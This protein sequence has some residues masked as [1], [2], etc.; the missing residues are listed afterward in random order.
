MMVPGPVA[1]HPEVLKA[2]AAQPLH[3]HDL[4]FVKMF[5]RVLQGLREVFRAP[6]GQPIL[7]NGG[8]LLAM[9]VACA[10]FIEPKD[11]ILIINNGFFGEELIRVTKC[12]SRNVE[13]LTVPLGDRVPLKEV[14][15][16][17]YSEEFQV[18]AVSH[19]DTGSGVK[20]QLRQLVQSAQRTDTLTIVDTVSSVGGEY[21]EQSRWGIDV[22]FASTQKAIAGPPGIALL[23]LSEKAMRRLD[24]RKE[25]ISSIYMNLKQWITSMQ[26]YELEE[27][28]RLVSTP[29]SNLVAALDVALHLIQ[30][31]GLQQRIQRH[32]Q[33]AQELRDGIISL[34]LTLVPKH[35]DYFS[36]TITTVFSPEHIAATKIAKQMLNQGVLIAPG[37]GQFRESLF[38]IGHMGNVTPAD[39]SITL[40]VLQ[41]T[42]TTL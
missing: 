21:L 29:A 3:P 35:P 25:P 31:E 33:N 19:I 22:C 23:M 34:G 11:H 37:L 41:Q 40:A 18:L 10:N 30:Q 42:L 24:A 39:I 28:P 5:R 20:A 1:C 8:G 32:Q 6:N 2:L 26:S 12:Y 4:D 36:N 38:R 15:A 13:T 27:V 9:E 14:Q 7:F 16:R 17:L